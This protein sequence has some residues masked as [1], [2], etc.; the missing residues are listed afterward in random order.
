[1]DFAEVSEADVSEAG[2]VHA[3]S[4]KE[5]HRG[6]C[7]AEF[8]ARH[9]P[10]AQAEYL[11]REMAAGKRVY[12]LRDPHPVGIVSV[13]GGLIENLYV[14]PKE[15]NR[16]Y[17]TALLQYALARCRGTPTLWILNTNQGAYRLYTRNGFRETGNRKQLNERLSE[18]ELAR[19]GEK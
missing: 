15:Q 4:W 3:E 8:V 13:W 11:R 10:A 1:M 12:M 19:C 14:L 5:S 16:G 6:F 18:I 7:G 9:T 17:G 2:Y